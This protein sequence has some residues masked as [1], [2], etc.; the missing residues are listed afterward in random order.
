MGASVAP[1]QPH[2]SKPSTDSKVAPA[3]NLSIKLKGGGPTFVTPT[4][5]KL[6]PKF[7]KDGFRVETLFGMSSSCL[8]GELLRNEHNGDLLKK[9]FSWVLA[10]SRTFNMNLYEFSS[11][12]KYIGGYFFVAQADAHS[13]KNPR[14]GH[15][16]LY[17]QFLDHFISMIRV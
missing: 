6:T 15:E 16:S 2:H 3:G 17:T 12:A 4:G 7:G 1:P 8:G 13:N 5:G 9:A 11:A 10:R 14:N